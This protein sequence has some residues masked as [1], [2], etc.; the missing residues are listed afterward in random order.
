MGHGHLAL[1]EFLIFIIDFALNG[2]FIVSPL[3]GIG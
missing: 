3:L 2:D 1:W